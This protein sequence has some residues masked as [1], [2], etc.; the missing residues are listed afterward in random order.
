MTWGKTSIYISHR[1]A[2]TRFCDRIFFIQDGMVVE[3]GTHEELMQKKG[4]YWRM[5]ELQSYYYQEQ[6]AGEEA[7]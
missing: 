3:A 1:L 6:L 2:S 5:F 4:Y 7:L